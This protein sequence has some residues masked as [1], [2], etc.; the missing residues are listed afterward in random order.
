MAPTY[1]PTTGQSQT[2][3]GVFE[4]KTDPS[5][6]NNQGINT[7]NDVDTLR[8]VEGQRQ[9]EFRD[10]NGN[11]T[12]A[13][14]SF[15]VRING[16]ELE[17]QFNQVAPGST[18][19][20]NS[21]QYNTE[22]VLKSREGNHAYAQ[23]IRATVTHADGTQTTQTILVAGDR[24][25][26]G[27]DGKPLPT[28]AKIPTSFGPNDKVKWEVVNIKENGGAIE[29]SG[30]TIDKNG[31]LAWE[32]MKN[33]GDYDF[34]DGQGAATF[35]GS[36]SGNF[37]QIVTSVKTT[38]TEV[39]I[40][41]ST[42]QTQSTVRNDATVVSVGSSQATDKV[43]VNEGNIVEKTRVDSITR[44]AA[45]DIEKERRELMRT[46]SRQF[47]T[48]EVDKQRGRVEAAQ[49]NPVVLPHATGVRV[50]ET[51]VPVNDNVRPEDR[52]TIYD[53]YKPSAQVRMGTDGGSFTVQ[54][55]PLNPNPDAPPTLVGATVTVNPAAGANQA[56]ITVTANITQYL[57]RTHKGATDMYGNE[58]KNPNPDGPRLL[59]PTGT[60]NNSRIVGYVPPTPDVTIP[61][62][63]IVSKNGV[64][65]LP[66]DKQVIISPPDP[67]KAGRGDA[68][69]TD[70]VGGL[71]IT[72]PDGTMVFKPQWTKAGY[73]QNATVLE[74]GQATK[75]MQA[76]VPQQKGQ[77][78]QLGQSYEVKKAPDGSYQVGSFKAITPDV[79]PQNF[80][81]IA[82]DTYA[83]EDTLRAGNVANEKF[84][85]RQGVHRHQPGGPD[86]ATVDVG[87]PG[88]D[89]S[90]QN[91]ARTPD[92]TIPGDPG[93]E[94]YEKTT[95]TTNF[96]VGASLTSGLGN[97]EDVTRR[98]T[99]RYQEDTQIKDV[100]EETRTTPGEIQTPVAD[101][102][103]TT[104]G[105]QDVANR[106]TTTNTRTTDSGYT[107][108]TTTNNYQ[109]DRTR[110]DTTNTPVTTTTQG[111]TTFDINAQGNLTNVQNT[112]GQ[113]TT[114]EGQST[115]TSTIRHGAEA[116]VGTSSV[117]SDRV[118]TG[119]STEVTGVSVETGAP[120]RVLGTS[121]STTERLTGDSKF[122]ATGATTSTTQV[123]SSEELGKTVVLLDRKTTVSKESHP[124]FAPV[125]GE[126][127][128]GVIHQWGGTPHTA[129][130]N[131][132]SL[133]LYAKGVVLGQSDKGAVGGVRLEVIL[134]PLGEEQ[135]PAYRVTKEGNVEPIYKTRPVKDA[136]GNNVYATLKDKDGK[137]MQVQVNEFVRDKDGNLVQ[138][139]TGTGR[140]N[141]PGIYLRV[142]KELI[143]DGRALSIQGGVKFDL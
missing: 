9:R 120:E 125:T 92:V 70:N 133:D 78:L 60:F 59:Q 21:L 66:K 35:G 119:T 8:T 69:Y 111:T 28:E 98:T 95:S 22:I 5:D 14:N 127:R 142:D 51:K 89:A 96:R 101:I 53:K 75:V 25:K 126:I 49:P 103:T 12:P 114:V 4:I 132:A 7:P 102:T 65:E 50:D 141:G 45:V 97:R 121:T 11:T 90:V 128:A 93:Q 58:I 37:Q 24:V 38:V 135:K 44:E 3:N 63:Q 79:H 130:A 17:R 6:L 131:S 129:A 86:I 82:Q 84:D 27:P 83:V 54:S 143:G 40:D 116:L 48:T 30:V 94:G 122:V 57:D 68:A 10:Q 139:T 91:T 105:Y 52:Q 88:T 2:T 19:D 33:G 62:T 20:Q 136:E 13:S 26:V 109:T 117:T 39:P 41:P 140:P 106:T 124:D 118:S 113:S 32:D 15:D 76:L 47:E 42:R 18:L 74:A 73:E 99:S 71:I 138:E 77:D 85:G 16:T 123:L 23:G 56:G 43:V 137:D 112:M 72:K 110:I 61:G 80:K 36:G 81:E 115:T 64:F 1:D 107:D 29:D 31:M 67:S 87:T 134:N 34:R 108:T 46:Q 104:T 100:V 55:A